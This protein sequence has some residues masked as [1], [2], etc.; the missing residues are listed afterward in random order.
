MTDITPH[1]SPHAPDTVAAML[2][3]DAFSRWLGIDLV[4]ARPGHCTLRMHVRADMMNGFGVSHGGV[5]YSLADSAMAFACNAGTHVTVAVDNQMTYPAAV[6]END[7]LIAT[8]DEEAA[9]GRLG[10]YRATVRNQHGTVVALFRGTVYRTGRP[11][12]PSSGP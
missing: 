4:A 9:P 11:H 5:A 6:H 2:E 3:R 12:S 8:A 10:F 7:E 1:I